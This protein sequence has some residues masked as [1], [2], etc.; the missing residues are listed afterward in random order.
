MS[1]RRAELIIAGLLYWEAEIAGVK[2]QYSD[3]Q[4]PQLRQQ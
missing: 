1:S 3:Q 2:E 4:F